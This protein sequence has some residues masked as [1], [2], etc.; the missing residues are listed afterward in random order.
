MLIPVAQ[1][2]EPYDIITCFSGEVNL[3]SASDELTIL[4]YDLK[5]VSRSNIEGGAF[6][7][8][9]CQIV[10]IVKIESGKYK[11]NFYGKYLAPDGDYIV[12]EGQIIGN[13]GTWQFIH[14][15]GKLKG[16]TGGG[17]N[18]PIRAKPIKKGTLQ[19]CSIATG[20]YELPQ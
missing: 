18:R 19:G 16:I 7:K 2:E 17:K 3:V 5:G 12:G 14:G 15:T 13:E 4:S 1:A 6:D 10:G 8:W 9:S 20:T 11:S